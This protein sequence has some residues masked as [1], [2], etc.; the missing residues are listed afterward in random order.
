MAP[1]TSIKHKHLAE[2]EIS[3]LNLSPHWVPSW[4]PRIPR[5]Y[6]SALQRLQH[7]SRSATTLRSPPSP[8]SSGHGSTTAPAIA[9]AKG[10]IIRTQLT[11]SGATLQQRSESDFFKSRAIV[12]KGCGQQNRARQKTSLVDLKGLGR[13]SSHYIL[14]AQ[15][16]PLTTPHTITTYGV[17]ATFGAPCVVTMISAVGLRP[18]RACRSFFLVLSLTRST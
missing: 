12:F 15:M 3:L 5:Q 4:R 6:F 18:C 8:L 17:V 14:I 7:G 16:P 11:M 1:A 10:S 13:P 2:P 9:A